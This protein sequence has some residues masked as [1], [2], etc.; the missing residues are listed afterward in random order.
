MDVKY[1][2]HPQDAWELWDSVQQDDTTDV[3][4]EE[5][6]RFKGL[7]SHFFRHFRIEL[8]AGSLMQFSTALVS[9]HHSGKIKVDIMHTSGEVSRT[10]DPNEML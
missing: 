10:L 1:T 3:S 5:V 9:S 7:Q 4:I 8:S 2:I 6:T